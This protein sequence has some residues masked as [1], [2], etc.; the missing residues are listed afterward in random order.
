LNQFHPVG[1]IFITILVMAFSEVSPGD[2]DAVKPA[3]QAIYNIDRIN[4]A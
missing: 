3:P 2:K 1:R 4:P